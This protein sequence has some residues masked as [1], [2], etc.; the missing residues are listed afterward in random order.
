MQEQDFGCAAACPRWPQA[1]TQYACIVRYEQISRPQE[2]ADVGEPAVLDV[3]RARDD[4]EPRG[5]ALLARSLRDQ[6]FR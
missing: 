4:Q 5:V 2:I 3:A 1:R 6:F